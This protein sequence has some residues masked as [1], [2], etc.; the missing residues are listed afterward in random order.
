MDK[1]V[2]AAIIILLVFVIAFVAVRFFMAG[3]YDACM[4]SC[5]ASSTLE[6]LKCSEYCSDIVNRGIIIVE[7][8]K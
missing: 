7:P 3:D 5:S 4:D 2:V 1:E 6:H 8:P